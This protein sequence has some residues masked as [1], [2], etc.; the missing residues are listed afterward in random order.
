MNDYRALSLVFDFE[1][2]GEKKQK[3]PGQKP[4]PVSLD[5]AGSSS[6]ASCW[7]R[8]GPSGWGASPP[9]LP[10]L[11]SWQT[12]LVPLNT[13]HPWSQSRS[14]PGYITPPIKPSLVVSRPPWPRLSQFND[15][16][17]SPPAHPLHYE[18]GFPLPL[19]LLPFYSVNGSAVVYLL[20]LNTKLVFT[21]CT[22]LHGI[23]CSR[24][25]FSYA[26]MLL[27]AIFR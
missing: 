1:F 13:D 7:N 2:I 8:S 15:H 3:K 27:H 14:L 9:W 16:P 11:P 10:R 23:M 20:L 6:R 22:A 18:T 21:W 4:R 5:V 19:Q 25:S 26:R 12:P 24:N 17:W